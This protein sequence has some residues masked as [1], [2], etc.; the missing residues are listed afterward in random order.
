MRFDG[1]KLHVWYC[2]NKISGNITDHIGYRTATKVGNQWRFSKEKIVLGPTP[3]TWDSRHTCDPSVIKGKFTLGE[4]VFSYLMVYLGCVTDD[5]K[6]NETGIAFSESIEGP[7]IKYNANPLIPYIGSKD[8][9]GPHVYWGYGQPCVVSVDKLGQCIIFYNV[10]I[11]ETFTRAEHWDLSDLLHP[12]KIRDVRLSDEG[13]INL[14]GQPDV[15]GNA[16]FAFDEKTHAFYAVGDMRIR[17]EDQP[18]YI[19]NA[20]P[21]LKTQLLPSERYPMATLFDAPIRWKTLFVVDSTVSGF[22]KN[23]N[24]GIL[25]D[26]YGW[27]EDPKDVLVGYT[28][29]DL[30]KMHPRRKGI[31]QSLHSYRI[32]GQTVP[33]K[34]KGL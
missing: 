28:V 8:F 19:S 14:I 34:G 17:G 16:D 6:D 5:C 7:W 1:K 12:R 4:K 3:G 32:F 27:L 11:A 2:T 15:I 10:G 22:A 9:P 33:V 25:T 20:L 23:H 29:S 31:W 13:Y 26:L 24:P 30:N 18:T 21:L